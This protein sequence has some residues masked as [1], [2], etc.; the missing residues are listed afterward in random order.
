MMKKALIGTL[1]IIF[2]CFLAVLPT[3]AETETIPNWAADSPAMQSIVAF[4]TASVDETSDGYIPKEDRIAVFDND[5]TLLGERFPTYFNDWLYI[6]RAL[7]DD[8]YEAP[9]ELK[10]FAQAWEDKVLRGVPIEDFDAKERELGPQLYKGL[11]VDE[12]AEVVRKFKAMPA[13]GFEGMTYGEAYFQPMVSL[14]E[15]LCAHDYTVYNVT[16][17]YRDAVR[18]MGEGVLDKYIPASHV[19][20]TDLLYVA[21]GDKNEDSMFYELTPEDELVIAGRLFLKN[22][23]T[24]KATMIQQEIGKMPVLAFGNSIGDFSMATYTLQN[25]KY[26]GRAY[27]LLCDDTERDYGD[28][29]V[30]ASFKAK[31]D[32]NGFYTVSMKDEFETIYPEGAKKA[33]QREVAQLS[34]Y[35]TEDSLAAENINAYLRAITNEASPDYIPAEDRVAV[36]DL[37][38]TLMCETYPFCFEYMVFADYAMNSGS[39]TVTDEVR[40]VAQE[41]MDAAGS[42]KKPD[43]MS[44]RQAAA[45]AVAYR[46][47]TMEELAEIVYSFKDSEAWG[48]SGMTRGEAFYL[49]MVELFDTLLKN[50]FTVYIVTATERNI[51]RAVIQ[52]TLNI[53]PSH[54][55]GTEYGYTATGQGDT[56]DGDYTFKST[57]KVVFDGAYYGENAKMSKVDAIVREIGQQPVLA[58]GNSG[59]DVAMCEYVVSN[60]PFPSLAYIVLADDEAREWGNYESAQAKIAGYN[61]QGIDTISMRDDF[62]TIYGEKVKKDMD[63]ASR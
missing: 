4:V 58:F 40:A 34:E 3:L 19:I 61:E 57:D 14:V 51:V 17:T 62:A 27:M 44:T 32:A 5:G 11:T 35:W 2:L 16:A 12:Y 20:G 18:V 25:K 7:Y 47:M 38:G 22:Q 24:N 63:A 23:K 41:I 55:I 48:F 31:C 1:L 33:G 8:T 43:G 56:A 21:S 50:D 45:G 59:G 10:A 42:R 46:G 37:D 6:Q 9:E 60:N 52:G 36:F 29:D 26:G 28:P 49:P 30:A 54:V 15:Y 13:W 39:D 53:P